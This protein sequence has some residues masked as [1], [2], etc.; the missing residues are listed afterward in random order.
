M[1]SPYTLYYT[2]PN[3]PSYT[4]HN[5]THPSPHSFPLELA[6]SWNIPSN[7]VETF[8][9]SLACPPSTPPRSRSKQ[10]GSYMNEPELPA[11]PDLFETDGKNEQQNAS[12]EQLAMQSV[13]SLS[14]KP[15]KSR[16][17][18]KQNFAAQP[19]RY[20]DNCQS[21][22]Q[23]EQRAPTTSPLSFYAPLPV[24]QPM[25]QSEA[26][27][28]PEEVTFEE[29]WAALDQLEA[30]LAKMNLEQQ[31][32]WFEEEFFPQMCLAF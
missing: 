27:E 1:Q 28:E 15:I 17:P 21:Q 5:Y 24:I 30:T 25:H 14:D 23:Q 10:C 22:F 6:H 7:T 16:L 18:R 13:F 32:R 29:A 20:L 2:I 3:T 9:S 8:T 31:S 19:N 11:P 26:V 4:P 12:P